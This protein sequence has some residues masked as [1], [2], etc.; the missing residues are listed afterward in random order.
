MVTRMAL[1]VQL[2]L[3]RLIK[4]MMMRMMMPCLPTLHQQGQLLRPKN[5]TLV[6]ELKNAMYY[7]AILEME[8]W[9]Q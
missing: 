5:Q 1:M 7:I 4:M 9:K 3:A 2:W 8:K 6:V